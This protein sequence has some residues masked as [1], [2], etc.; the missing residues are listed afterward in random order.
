[1]QTL[2]IFVVVGFLAQMIDGALGMAY[3]V[4]STT[5][6]LS[7]GIPPAIASATVHISEVFT[8][9]VSGISHFKFK[10]LDKALFKRLLLPGI[11]GGIIGAYLLTN[12]SADTIK[13]FVTAYLIVMGIIILFKAFKR[14]INKVEFSGKKA[15]GLGLAGGF[16]DAV[17][18]GGWGPIVTSTLMANGH[19]PRLAIG[20]VNTVEFF[21]TMAQSVTFITFLGLGQNWQGVLGLAIGGVLAAPLAAF[22]CSKLPTKVIMIMVGGVIVSLNVR[23][24]IQIWF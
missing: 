11:A 16:F 5:F 22:A 13:P 4:S 24:L 17:G 18:G 23:A 10:N 3:G 12:I 7:A 9:F 14:S 21:V 6:L 2:I 1:M 8:T 15:W 20:T 19:T